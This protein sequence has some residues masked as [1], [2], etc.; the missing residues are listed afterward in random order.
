MRLFPGWIGGWRLYQRISW[1]LSRNILCSSSC[2]TFCITFCITVTECQS[3]SLNW[4]P[5]PPL[6]PQGG[7]STRLLVKGWGEPIRMTARR[8]SLTQVH[9]ED[10]H[11]VEV[12]GWV[13]PHPLWLAF[14]LK[15]YKNAYLVKYLW[16]EQ[17]WLKQ[18]MFAIWRP[19]LW[20]MW[21]EYSTLYR[22]EW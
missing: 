11:M 1:L 22:K 3:L 17:R 16:K 15:K 7:G 14:T 21:K 13:S 12:Q 18:K 2:F 5:P 20:G 9:S 19:V 6:E 8:E 4:L 10:I